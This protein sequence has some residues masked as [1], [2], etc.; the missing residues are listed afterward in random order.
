[1]PVCFFL[2]YRNRAYKNQKLFIVFLI[3]IQVSL[4][5]AFTTLDLL[6]FFMAFES[7]LIPM[8]LMIGI[9]GTNKRRVKA[10]YLFFMYSFLSALFSFF[11]ILYIY[12]ITGT[13]D[14]LIL[15]DFNF[16]SSQQI[17]A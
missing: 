6:I 4:I 14:L 7:I 5:I 9:F 3:F 10:S 8:S 11:L 15:L 16:N 2:E 12:S 17:F 13:F 1:M